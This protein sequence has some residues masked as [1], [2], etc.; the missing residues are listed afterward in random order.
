M[1]SMITDKEMEHYIDNVP[2]KRGGKIGNKKQAIEAMKELGWTKYSMEE[3][4][5]AFSEDGGCPIYRIGR[6]YYWNGE[7]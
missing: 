2:V 3:M 7:Y 6:T 1:Y 4:I 5:Q